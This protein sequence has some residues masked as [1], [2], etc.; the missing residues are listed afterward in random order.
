M[1]FPRSSIAI[2]MAVLL[3]AGSL[4]AQG[5]A[6]PRLSVKI[7]SLTS[8]IS[9]GKQATIEVATVPNASCKI[10]VTYDSGPSAAKG[11]EPKTADANG[12]VSWTWNV[13]TT[14]TPGK[15]PVAV[16]GSSGG[17]EATAKRQLVVTKPT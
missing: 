7:V 11:L 8:P 9:G 5:H 13:G 4:V 6:A 14:T 16:T 2:F 17:K 12:S 3:V 10:V 1:K 15:W